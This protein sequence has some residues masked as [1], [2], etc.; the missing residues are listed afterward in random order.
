VSLLRR[1]FNSLYP[2]ACTWLRNLAPSYPGCTLISSR[3]I[4]LIQVDPLHVS[5]DFSARLRCSYPT[6]VFGIGIYQ[7]PSSLQVPTS[8]ALTH[9]CLVGLC[10]AQPFISERSSFA[11]SPTNSYWT[12]RGADSLRSPA[13][14]TYR[15]AIARGI[16]IGPLGP[17]CDTLSSLVGTVAASFHNLFNFSSIDRR[18]Q[19]SLSCIRSCRPG[20]NRK[21]H[22]VT[23][24]AHTGLD[25]QC[26]LLLINSSQRP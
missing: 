2:L 19:D 11:V 14:A 25:I 26:V 8:L 1:Y 13:H 21:G 22:I 9:P 6:R 18:V 5:S 23:V 20:T 15:V 16:R 4:I 7:L 17:F 24:C 3:T 12:S 10:S